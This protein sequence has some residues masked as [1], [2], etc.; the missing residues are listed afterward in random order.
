MIAADGGEVELLAMIDTLRPEPRATPG[1]ALDHAAV[2]R[3]VLTDV[4]GWGGTAS[5]TV[6]AL[7]QMEPAAQLLYAARRVGPRMLPP[8]RVPEIAALTRVR[9]ANHNALVDFQPQPYAGRLTYFRSRGSAS[10]SSA[11][12]TLRY[13]GRLAGSIGVHDVAGAH[14]TLLDRPHVDTL[15]DALRR[16]IA[17]L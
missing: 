14:G 17:A 6:E 10:L 12:E 3:R 11:D 1:L 9:M 5:V 4:F 8:E 15:A 13:W 16:V 2:L 7:R